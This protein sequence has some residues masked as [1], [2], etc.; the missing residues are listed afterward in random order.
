MLFHKCDSMFRLPSLIALALSVC[1]FASAVTLQQLSLD[2][3]TQAATAIVRVRVTGAVPALAGSMIYTH[4]QLQVSETWKGVATREVVLPGGL[5]GGFRQS[6]PG[7]PQLKT[8]SEYVLFLWTSAG[9]V[10]HLLGMTQGIFSV[11]Q[12]PDGVLEV[13]RA[14]IGETMRDASGHSVQDHAVQMNLLDMK[15][16]VRQ[17]TGQGGLK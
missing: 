10:T 5:A 14:R 12:R 8:G 17:M 2:E 13:S 7:V 11:S 16:Q 1:A 6:F 9:G 3:M 15:K 4:Y